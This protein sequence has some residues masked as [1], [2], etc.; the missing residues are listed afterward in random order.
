MGGTGQPA[1]LGRETG[2][3]MVVTGAYYLE[4]N[5]IQL[6]VKLSDVRTRSLMEALDPVQGHRNQIAYLVNTVQEGVM[7]TL[8]YRVDSRFG[9]HEGMLKFP[10]NYEAYRAYREGMEIF[11]QNRY[12]ESTKYFE[13]AVQL[14]S[15]FLHALLWAAK[16]HIVATLDISYRDTTAMRPHLERYEKIMDLLE[17]QIN[18][19]S[20]YDQY[21]LKFIQAI[22]EA[23]V[24]AMYQAG[25]LA[26]KAAPGSQEAMR[27][28]A[29]CAGWSGRD[30]EAVKLLL[31]LDTEHGLMSTF[32]GYVYYLCKELHDLG[33]HRQELKVAKKGC[34]FHPN[35]W[36]MH[37]MKI[38]A[39][40]ALGRTKKAI[41]LIEKE[42]HNLPREDARRVFFQSGHEAFAH[43]FPEM[44]RT[45][46]QRYC[47]EVEYLTPKG[48]NRLPSETFHWRR[49]L[50]WG[51]FYQAKYDKAYPLAVKLSLED[52]TNLDVKCLR[53]ILAAQR[54]KREEALKMS[55]DI[56]AAMPDSL[57]R[58]KFRTFGVWQALIAAW[59]GDKEKAV[60]LLRDYRYDEA[61]VFGWRPCRSYCG[62]S[63]WGYPPFEELIGTK[64]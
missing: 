9:Q 59:L 26:M 5:D 36:E 51:L 35:K 46:F 63:L 11:L 13:R 28:T 42:I 45:F 2:A 52:P 34:R 17:K 33:K 43:G 30:N 48:E 15:T 60:Q 64:D 55:D 29:Q 4:G 61:W 22:R 47:D 19:L 54:G 21:Y 7:T 25:H 32:V 56:A 37:F 14:D 49:R 27:E 40:I 41:A 12:A 53:G 23:D 50:A 39:L 31:Q 6:H 3:G 8:A 18:D 38:R 16:G 1:A 44:G 62:K 58:H 57:F 24:E 10:P 20:E